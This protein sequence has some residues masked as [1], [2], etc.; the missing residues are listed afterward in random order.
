MR[1][2][3]AETS[4]ELVIRIRRTA[5]S[6]TGVS[7]KVCRRA[8][9]RPAWRV[10][11]LPEIIDAVC[12]FKDASP[13]ECVA[14][15]PARPP[16]VAFRRKA[17]RLPRPSP[18]RPGD[19]PGIVLTM[20]SVPCAAGPDADSKPIPATPQDG[21][22]LDGNI[23][24]AAIASD[25]VTAPDIGHSFPDRHDGGCQRGEAIKTSCGSA[26]GHVTF[27]AVRG[28]RWRRRSTPSYRPPVTVSGRR[29]TAHR[30]R[31]AAAPVRRP[32]A[33]PDGTCPP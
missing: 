21:A 27:A 18:A 6:D 12:G 23:A 20:A 31:R 11:D 19:F 16:A 30:Q 4:P 14:A 26:A 15:D 10:E 5:G 28:S 33:A 29:R 7:R 9:P 8:S 22:A 17:W 25:P 32:Y 2:R 3:S 1:R 24:S 13:R